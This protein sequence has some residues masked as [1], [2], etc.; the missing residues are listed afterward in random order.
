MADGRNDKTPGARETHRPRFSRSR[1][2]ATPEF[3]DFKEG[4]KKLLAVPKAVLDARVKAAKEASPRAGN[5]KAAGAEKNRQGK[6]NHSG[7]TPSQDDEHSINQEREAPGQQE[8]VIA[9]GTPLPQR[10]VPEIPEI[11]AKQPTNHWYNS[12]QWWKSRP[13]D[14]W[15]VRVEFAAL[16]F[17]IGYAIITYCQ[18]RDSNRN[19]R[20]DQ[21]AWVH[22]S[23]DAKAP[24]NRVPLV[25]GSPLVIPVIL[26]NTGKTPAFGVRGYVVLSLLPAGNV[27][28][29]LY[30]P[31]H[32]RVAI[33]VESMYPGT[34][35][36]S[37][38]V[39]LLGMENGQLSAIKLTEP[40]ITGIATGTM[41]ITIHG[42]IEY[43]DI[44]GRDHWDT[45]CYTPNMGGITKD[46]RT[47]KIQSAQLPR[48][49]E[50]NN[51]DNN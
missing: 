16:F 36:D 19:F 18:W 2:E 3:A 51:S 28:E 14:W 48:C 17:G 33:Q 45:F 9:S 39:V 23:I 7:N 37:I 22:R 13:V 25:I 38:P 6:M 8:N 12:F 35:S 42:R 4:M 15:K 47:V 30:A 11:K 50:D 40:Q 41:T 24:E 34:N 10:D 27:P 31:G 43:R 32:P 26:A 1:F 5:P 21:R 20:I 44:F 46:G 49:V 29:F